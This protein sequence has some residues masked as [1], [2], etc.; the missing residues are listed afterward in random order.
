[1]QRRR[2]TLGDDSDMTVKRTSPGARSIRSFES[3]IPV[4]DPISFLLSFFFFF[5]FFVCFSFYFFPPFYPF[6][7]SSYSVS[8]PFF[9]LRPFRVLDPLLYNCLF[10]LSFNPFP[11]EGRNPC[12]RLLRLFIIPFSNL[13]YAK[14]RKKEKSLNNVNNVLLLYRAG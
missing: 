4:L 7:I 1:M 6:H 5:F 9:F 14:I 3:A 10:D 8:H 11:L 13:L 2:G 12:S